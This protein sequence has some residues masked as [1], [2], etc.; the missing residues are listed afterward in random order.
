MIANSGWPEQIANKGVLAMTKLPVTSNYSTIIDA[1]YSAA[2]NPASYVNFMEIWE[3][4]IMQPWAEGAKPAP[5]WNMDRNQLAVHF[6]QALEIFEVKKMTARTSVKAF[7]DSQKFAAAIIRQNGQ[8][9]SSNAAFDDRFDL[10]R[11]QSFFD[12]LETPPTPKIAGDD[13]SIVSMWNAGGGG[14]LAARYHFAN[15]TSSVVMIEAISGESFADS[16]EKNLLLIKSCQAQWSL[17]GSSVLVNSFGLTPA[18]MEVSHHLY[19]GL[20]V[21]D[22]ARARKTSPETIRKQI[23]SILNKVQV[24]S[25]SEFIGMVTGIM[26]VVDVVPHSARHDEMS[27]TRLNSFNYSEIKD[28]PGGKRVRFYHY[29]HKEGAPVLFL[30]GHTSSA[31]PPRRLVEAASN[32]GLQIIAPCKPGIEETSL[33]DGAFEPMDFIADCMKILDGL[34]I[35]KL[36]IAGH[37]MSGVYAI[38]AAARYPDRFSAFAVLDTGIPLIDENQFLRMPEGSRRIFMTAWQAPEFLY[39]PF[40]FAADAFLASDGD[41]CEFMRS[42]FAASQHDL[43]LLEDPELYRIAHKSMSDF[44]GT[45]RRSVDELLYW[46]SDWTPHLKIAQANTQ[47]LLIHSER[48]DWLNAGEIECYCRNTPNLESAIIP[49]TAQLFIYE[50]PDNFC[51]S[52]REVCEFGDCNGD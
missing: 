5:D 47:G 10:V 14:A 9:L 21:G 12:Q 40:A 28:L 7:L 11:G 23:K 6:K 50:K 18:E 41:G 34:G 43:D 30:H 24:S 42:Q 3:S 33:P 31:V 2:M 36:P 22:I 8:L 4:R 35:E 48:H 25:Q 37:A 15:G 26:H 44:M 38:E 46:V 27:R 29:G 17:W 49:E 51:K 13:K 45:A 39:A 1:I 32:N 20:H 16:S 19:D 52:L